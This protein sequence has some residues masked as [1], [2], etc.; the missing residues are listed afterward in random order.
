MTLEMS[1]YFTQNVP[2]KPQ[3]TSRLG[4]LAQLQPLDAGEQ[5]PRLRLHPEARSPEQLS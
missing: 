2:P 1:G 5:P 3:Q 4:H